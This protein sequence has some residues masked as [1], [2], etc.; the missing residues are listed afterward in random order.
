VV[1]I[2]SQN[3]PQ[4]AGRKGPTSMF[5][6][7]VLLVSIVSMSIPF[8]V[9]CWAGRKLQNFWQKLALFL[10]LFII[11]FALF[12]YTA[13]LW[14]AFHPADAQTAIYDDF[15]GYT[16]EQIVFL[17]V[18]MWFG[19]WRMPKVIQRYEHLSAQRD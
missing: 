18:M 7:A 4:A 6:P 14:I 13:E 15:K 17:F 16:R 2:A 3:C 11:G 10:I 5:G 1:T 12:C 9:A 19:L 8:S